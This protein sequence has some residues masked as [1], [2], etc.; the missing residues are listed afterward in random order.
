MLLLSLDA[1]WEPEAFYFS[2]RIINV[3]NWIIATYDNDGRLN[4]SAV[5]RHEIAS[6]RPL[7]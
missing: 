3:L 4:I 6:E 2:K 7:V 1:D 5:G